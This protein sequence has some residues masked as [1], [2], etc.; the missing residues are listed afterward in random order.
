MGLGCRNVDGSLSG[1][2]GANKRGCWNVCFGW[3]AEM[4]LDR[5]QAFSI[6]V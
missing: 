2:G 5:A 3:N 6:E 1:Y 4:E